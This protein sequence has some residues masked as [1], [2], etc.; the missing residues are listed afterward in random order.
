M[1]ENAC[2]FQG[3]II[4][5]FFFHLLEPYPIEIFVVITFSKRLV[6]LCIDWH[7]TSARSDGYHTWLITTY[8]VNYM[9]CCCVILIES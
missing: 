1:G 5:D 2:S 4:E 6:F 7:C 9:L 3:N 8:H